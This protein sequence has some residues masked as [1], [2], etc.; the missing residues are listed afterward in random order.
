MPFIEGISDDIVTIIC[1]VMTIITLVVSWL[2]TN[3]T[4]LALPTNLFLIERSTRRVYTTNYV[5]NFNRS[6]LFRVILIS[7]QKLSFK[8]LFFK[9]IASQRLAASSTTT[10]STIINNEGTSNADSNNVI[11]PS[12][13]DQNDGVDEIVEQALVE[14]LLEGTIYSTSNI[15]VQTNARLSFQ[16]SDGH[17][18]Q[19]SS[20]SLSYQR[21]LF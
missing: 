10:T 13:S 11:S 18:S 6:T 16:N 1:I 9:V 3:V 21:F 8:I 12:R 4:D 15:E 17:V 19:G 5:G 14:N 2:S 7:K 20:S